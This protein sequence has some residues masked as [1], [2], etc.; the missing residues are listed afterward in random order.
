MI[1]LLQSPWM[2][3][4]IYAVT[5]AETRPY[6]LNNNDKVRVH[7]VYKRSKMSLLSPPYGYVIATLPY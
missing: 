1:W 2:P 7:R 4:E 5:H 3:I 6:E